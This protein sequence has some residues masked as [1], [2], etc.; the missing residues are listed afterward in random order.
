MSC[1]LIFNTTG[2][3]LNNFFQ[4]TCKKSIG[5]DFSFKINFISYLKCLRLDYED[6]FKIFVILIEV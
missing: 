3:Y 5:C 6:I 4:M 1:N 2:S